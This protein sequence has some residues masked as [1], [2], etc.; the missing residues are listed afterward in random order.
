MREFSKTLSSHMF[1]FAPFYQRTAAQ[2]P[3]GAKLAEIG[4]ADGVSAIFLAEAMLNLGKEF[5]FY[6]V[7]SLAYGGM[8][9]LHTI[10]KNVAAAD[11][12]KWVEIIPHDSLAASCRFPDNYFDFVFIDASHLYEPTKADIR[13]WYYKV[14]GTGILAGHD[15]HHVEV[16]RAVAEV[17]P[18]MSLRTESTEKECGVWWVMKKGASYE[19]NC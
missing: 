12:F 9:Q 16:N 11:L 1:D 7:D 14:K 8:D 18:G 2:M 13:L 10:I 5:Q 4:I 3:N 19:L 15:Y 17:I 6:L